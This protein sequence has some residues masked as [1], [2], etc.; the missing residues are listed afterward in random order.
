[1]AQ[2]PDAITIASIYHNTH[3]THEKKGSK[4]KGNFG[5]YSYSNCKEETGP[6]SP[7]RQQCDQRPLPSARRDILVARNTIIAKRSYE[8]RR[9]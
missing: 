7:Q 1:M 6:Y 9:V 4:S 2:L 8:H 3:I 5:N